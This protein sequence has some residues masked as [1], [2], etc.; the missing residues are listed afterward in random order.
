MLLIF[1]ETFVFYIFYSYKERRIDLF[2]V[3]LKNISAY[4]RT[5]LHYLE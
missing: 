1:C 2:A 4:F 3:G 5:S